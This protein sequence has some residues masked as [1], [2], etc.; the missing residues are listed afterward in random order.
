[1]A[2]ASPHHLHA[3]TLRLDQGADR[4]AD[5]CGNVL[6]GGS[7]PPLGV[8]VRR[9]AAPDSRD[10]GW[11]HTP[12]ARLEEQAMNRTH[13]PV[14]RLTTALAPSRPRRRTRLRATV[15]GAIAAAAVALP[16][17]SASAVDVGFWMYDADNDGV[18]DASAVDVF[19]N[20]GT[21]GSDGYLDANLLD[22]SGNGRADTWLVDTN[23][24]NVV[25]H[26]GFDRGEDGRFEE[27]NV[28]A[29]EDGVI[30]AVFVDQ[31][32]DGLP[33]TMFLGGSGNPTAGIDWERD[34]CPS[35]PF[36]CM[37]WPRASNNSDVTVVV[38][39]SSLAAGMEGFEHSTSLSGGL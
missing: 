19:G 24:N 21:F 29:D 13:P 39:V 11:A 25:D 3:V 7:S 38:N 33:E 30:E 35:D 37:Q 1:M 18:V 9:I 34:V 15:V 20:G 6:V 17:G 8:L 5:P 27:W 16:V 26:I 32:G 36:W 10:S 12:D 31:D 2:D 14:P 23:Q 22:V 4:C 28:D